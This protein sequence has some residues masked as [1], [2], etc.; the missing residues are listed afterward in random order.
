IK[1]P[2]KD[3]SL[4]AEKVQKDRKEYFNYAFNNYLRE[5]EKKRV[6]TIQT[7]GYKAVELDPLI[8]KKDVENYGLGGFIKLKKADYVS[9][10]KYAREV[11][12]RRGKTTTSSAR[13]HLARY[14]PNFPSSE[15]SY[16]E[17]ASAAFPQV[18]KKVRELLKSGRSERQTRPPRDLIYQALRELFLAHPSQVKV[19]LIVPLLE[20]D[21]QQTQQIIKKISQSRYILDK[22]TKQGLKLAEK[23][24]RDRATIIQ[25]SGLSAESKKKLLEK[26]VKSPKT[27]LVPLKKYEPHRMDWQQKQK[28]EQQLSKKAVVGKYT[29]PPDVLEEW[30]YQ[31]HQAGKEF[32][33]EEPS[34]VY[35]IPFSGETN[36]L[37]KEEERFRAWQK[38]YHPDKSS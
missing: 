33:Y 4:L 22:E 25:K 15:A 2:K 24:R 17:L 32:H 14:I 36:F 12:V 38:V 11:L 20:K 7:L 6:E 21:P 13:W 19:K 18:Q 5:I 23:L 35:E 34:Q 30:K 8:T 9:A 27:G 16:N 10:F 37:K 28:I 1:M 31:A 29:L 26:L 3:K